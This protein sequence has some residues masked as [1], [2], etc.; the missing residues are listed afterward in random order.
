VTRSRK[1]V[2]A[3]LVLGLVSLALALTST[4]SSA[5]QPVQITI[6]SEQSFWRPAVVD[7]LDEVFIPRFNAENPHIQIQPVIRTAN[8]SDR[9]ERLTAMIAA[10]IAPDIV[11]VGHTAANTEGVA[12]GWL[13][14]LD[15]YLESWDD[16]ENIVPIS[17]GHF[18]PGGVTY[19]I[20]QGAT[21]R[22]IAYNKRFHAEAGLGRE[23]TPATW[24]E[25]LEMS[26]RLLVTD[27][28]RVI[29]RGI[30]LPSA[31]LDLAQEF[32]LWAFVNG[33]QILTED[34]TAP[35]FN[36]DAGL[37]A[38]EFVRRQYEIHNPPG[39]QVTGLSSSPRTGWFREEVAMFRATPSLGSELRINHPHMMDD[40]G[41]FFLPPRTTDYAPGSGT[42]INGVGIMSLS[43]HPDEAWEVL[44]AL[45]SS[46]VNEQFIRLSGHVSTRR[47]MIPVVLDS[48]PEL[49]PWYE[50]MEV[51]VP[52]PGW[53][54]GAGY[55]Y[56]SALGEP[57]RSAVRGEMPVETALEE[58]ARRVQI[59][60]N[61]FW[62]EVAA[63]Q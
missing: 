42:S 21:P 49:L 2:D 3:F 43:K 15:R 58:A 45:L 40:L 47:D 37:Q 34:R 29:R 9:G 27:D 24:D 38:L 46:E 56:S 10:G 8:W 30:H 13:L 23:A 31:T 57:V 33:G 28:T 1:V 26:Q 19:A 50:V 6:V 36:T 62:E 7:W 61:A 53:P 5:Q 55:N 25:M 32:Q 41:T 54:S 35:A 12:R 59:M 14:P 48:A 4:A 44:S 18:R 20:P 11:V 17:W 39:F 60:L 22:V 63:L 51:A 52:F 16:M